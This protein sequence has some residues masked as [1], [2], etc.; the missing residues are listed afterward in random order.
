MVCGDAYRILKRE[1]CG[2][3]WTN[4]SAEPRASVPVPMTNESRLGCWA[5][6]LDESAG[7]AR[8]NAFL[9]P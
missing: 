8:F 1:P 6:R 2:V 9:V 7:D 5:G 3:R 4:V